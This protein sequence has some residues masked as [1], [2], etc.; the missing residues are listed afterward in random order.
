MT[1]SFGPYSEQSPCTGEEESDESGEAK[2]RMV[3]PELK[4]SYAQEL[5]DMSK[6]RGMPTDA[7][8]KLLLAHNEILM[9]RQMLDTARNRLADAY[10]YIERMERK[11]RPRGRHARVWGEPSEKPYAI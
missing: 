10:T 3:V 5:A 1:A 8:R 2:R 7:R 9:L 6:L 4:E 11:T